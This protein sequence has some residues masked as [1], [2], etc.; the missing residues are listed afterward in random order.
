MRQYY[1]EPTLM[2]ISVDSSYS[3]VCRQEVTGN[4]LPGLVF[5]IVVE[6]CMKQVLERYYSL[7]HSGTIS[8]ND[9]PIHVS[10]PGARKRGNRCGF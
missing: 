3:C 4:E 2:G 9:E 1:N 7:A 10:P 6:T 5:E 8:R